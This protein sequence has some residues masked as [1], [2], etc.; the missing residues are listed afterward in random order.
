MGC[1]EESQEVM[2]R[3]SDQALSLIIPKAPVLLCPLLALL[4]YFFLVLRPCKL[5]SADVVLLTIG[6]PAH[7]TPF[8]RGAR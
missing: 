1:P 8:A 2:D 7:A 3:V 4:A 5:P 6:P